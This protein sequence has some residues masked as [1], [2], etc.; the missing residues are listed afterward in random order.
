MASNKTR[1]DWI[2]YTDGSGYHEGVSVSSATLYRTE[3]LKNKYGVFR[4]ANHSTVLH[5][6]LEA[7]VSSIEFAAS[8]LRDQTVFYDRDN[9]G[10]IRTETML[11]FC[12]NDS[13]V[14]ALNAG[15]MSAEGDFE[16][17]ASRLLV[18]RRT[19][20]PTAVWVKRN[21]HK[22]QA[23]ADHCASNGRVIIKD[24]LTMMQ[25][26]QHINYLKKQETKP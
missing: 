18:A 10:G 15:L 13:A 26:E 20:R 2:G 21:T 5:A 7:L 24:F 6:E 1:Y 4:A 11:L 12:D 22:D 19:I 17:F 23:S 9:V 16:S 8:W 25:E 3:D 14:N